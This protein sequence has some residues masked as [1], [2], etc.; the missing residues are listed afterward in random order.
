MGEVAAVILAAGLGKRM[1]SKYPKVL[2]PVGGRPMLQHVLGAAEKAGVDEILVVLG[3]GRDIIL[4]EFEH[5]PY[6]VQ[7]QQLGTGHAL[8]Q[9]RDALK[10]HVEHVLVLCGDVPLIKPETLKELMDHHIESGSY[11][12]ILT[13]EL[14]NPKGYGRIIRDDTGN[15][16]GIVEHRDASPEELEIK[17]VNSGTYV[18][19]RKE[20]FEALDRIDTQNAQGEYYLTDVIGILFNE[21]KTVSA[22][23]TE[24]PTEIMGINDRIQL[25]EAER[26]MRRRKNEE[27]MLYGVT[28][29]DS[30]TTRIDSGV[31]IAPDTIIYPFT[32]IEGNTEIGEDCRIGP[33]TTIVDCVIGK[34]TMIKNSVILESRIGSHC[35]VGPFAHIRPGTVLE[36]YVKVGDFVE[37]KKSKIG[38]GSKVP[39][40]SYVGD[41][42]VEEKV[43][44]GAGTIT[45]N[46]DGEKKWKTF[47][48]EGAFIGSNTSLVAPVR[49]GKR[50]FV[51]AG[52][53]ITRDVPGEALAIARK[54]QEN[55]EG[56]VRKRKK[57]DDD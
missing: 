23:M 34:D 6:V 43:N 9:C 40:L 10:S 15:V 8:Y 53:T 22:V 41:A 1:R 2:H 19:K 48:D 27:L 25:A 4:D 18:F 33:F 36:D 35:K 20:L 51:A 55:I 54:K 29:L 32:I 38:E 42:E 13:A 26:I 30:E 52:S 44:I 47:I 12:T 17:E 39:H 14:P 46:Y 11:A 56:W 5:I 50:A 21:G 31:K 24:D 28:I 45:C 57:K 3:H 49:I 37:I 16:K 7:E